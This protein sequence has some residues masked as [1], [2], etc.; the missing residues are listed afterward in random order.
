MRP[1]VVVDDA[2]GHDT[3][4]VTTVLLAKVGFQVADQIVNGI[5][6]PLYLKLMR[7]RMR[8]APE[9]VPA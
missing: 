4:P 2:G 5:V 8:P 9:Q 6:Y 7:P 3:W 1:V